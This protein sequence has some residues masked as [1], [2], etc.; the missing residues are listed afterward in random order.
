MQLDLMVPKA[1]SN[2]FYRQTY[3]GV[4]NG[5]YH[6]NYVLKRV[7]IGAF[8]DFKALEPRN[9]FLPFVGVSTNNYPNN[10]LSYGISSGYQLINNELM[11]MDAKIGLGLSNFTQKPIIDS[12]P[13]LK[14]NNVLHINSSIGA[15]WY[16]EEYKLLLVGIQL[17]YNY[18]QTIIQPSDLGYVINYNITK[19]KLNFLSFGFSVLYKIGLPK[20]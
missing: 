20:E 1:L 2:N 6:F 7:L 3:R 17:K 16:V 4:F 9:N 19:N 13:I 18:Y 12:L 14:L 11:I 8:V 5:N 15:Y 10:Y